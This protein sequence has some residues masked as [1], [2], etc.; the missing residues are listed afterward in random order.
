MNAWHVIVMRSFYSM[1][2]PTAIIEAAKIDGANEY[3][4][5]FKIVLHISLPCLLYTSLLFLNT[6]NI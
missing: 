2:I 3:Q 4:I 5:Y 1:S 6:F